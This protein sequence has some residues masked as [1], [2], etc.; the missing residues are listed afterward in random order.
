[1]LAPACGERPANDAQGEPMNGT[2]AEMTAADDAP[3]LLTAKQR[4]TIAA[5][6]TSRT[7]E[8]AMKSAG[9]TRQTFYKWLKVPAFRDELNRQ[10]DDFTAD[11]I[12]QLKSAAGEAVQTLRG[13]LASEN[14]NV[15][16]RAALGII[17]QINK[18]K[19]LEIT[20]RLDAIE[21]AIEEK[22]NGRY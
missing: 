15:R 7:H 11:A 22:G 18:A 14:E 16:L 20:A 9:I 6:I 8:D 4:R 19:E 21:K 3:R 2:V 10:L 12:G 1:L 17:D 5:I 13:L